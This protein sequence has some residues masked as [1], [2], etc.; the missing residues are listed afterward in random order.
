MDIKNGEPGDVS[1]FSEKMAGYD[2][3][4]EDYDYDDVITNLVEPLDKLIIQSKIKNHD[5]EGNQSIDKNLCDDLL[6][7]LHIQFLK[8]MK[9][10]F[11]MP[12]MLSDRF[13]S[14]LQENELFGQVD[15]LEGYLIDEWNGQCKV[16]D[17][18]PEFILDNISKMEEEPQSFGS[19]SKNKSAD[20]PVQL[21]TP[22]A[23]GG[24]QM[25]PAQGGAQGG[26]MPPAQGGAQGGEAPAF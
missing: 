25:P 22:P 5:G 14:I 10:E 13:F 6:P 16:E 15:S 23:Q 11:E 12:F 3:H 18:S 17:L 1:R 4:E 26:E 9:E 19:T 21:E 24:A 20:I 2:F 7:S 8:Y